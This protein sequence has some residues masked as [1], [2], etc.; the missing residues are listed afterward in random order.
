MKIIF[1]TE[2]DNYKDSYV[3][4]LKYVQ[5]LYPEAINDFL[6]LPKH[7]ENGKRYLSKQMKQLYP[8]KT[9]LVRHSKKLNGIGYI[10]GHIG[11]STFRRIV[12]YF[13]K[14]INKQYDEKFKLN[15]K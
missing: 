4:V 11:P 5:S 15:I 10:P 12:N 2:S 7:G 13:S 8:N 14:I 3:I 1:E 6:K 9:D